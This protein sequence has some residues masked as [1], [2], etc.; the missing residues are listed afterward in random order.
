MR[1]QIPGKKKQDEKTKKTGA[2]NCRD[3]IAKSSGGGGD[4]GRSGLRN[5]N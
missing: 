4:G 5:P 3:W 2:E 1:H